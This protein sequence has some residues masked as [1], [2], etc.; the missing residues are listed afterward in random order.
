LHISN[1]RSIL[2]ALGPLVP[3]SVVERGAREYFNQRF[4]AIGVMTAL[5]L[6]QVNR[7]ATLDL[8]LKGESQPLHV[9][10]DRY[11]LSTSGGKTYIEI[12]QLT[13][14]KEWMTALASQLLKGRKHEVPDFVSGFL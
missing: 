11:E 13:A 2:K 4:Q 10:I 5:Q 14:S 7:R 3:G 8:E 9:V 1:F 12:K 6:D